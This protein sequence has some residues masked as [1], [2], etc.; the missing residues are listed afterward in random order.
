MNYNPGVKLFE[1]DAGT[2]LSREKIEDELSQLTK[3]LERLRDRMEEARLLN[4]TNT[5]G[6]VLSFPELRQLLSN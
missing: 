4:A 6:A 1:D 3:S 2:R 5:Y